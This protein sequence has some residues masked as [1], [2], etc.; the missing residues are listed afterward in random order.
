MKMKNLFK[1]AV[2]AG[3]I[4]A[5]ITVTA[6]NFNASA[7]VYWK[8][9]YPNAEIDDIDTLCTQTNHY[10]VYGS[11]RFLKA[12]KKGDIF[13]DADGSS[14][15]AGH[16]AIVEGVFYN[17]KYNKAYIRL[18]EAPGNGQLVKRNV[19]DLPRFCNNR[20][21]KILR[22]K[23]VTE[24]QITSA[25]EFCQ[26][27]IGIQYPTEEL[28]NNCSAA[29]LTFSILAGNIPAIFSN[30]RDIWLNRPAKNY[31]PVDVPYAEKSWYCSELIYAAYYTATNGAIDLNPGDNFCWP[32]EIRDSEYV[33]NV[34]LSACYSYYH[35]YDDPELV[36]CTHAMH[37][38]VF[39]GYDIG[40]DYCDLVTESNGTQYCRDCHHSWNKPICA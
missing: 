15:I 25:I 40:Y 12:L 18:I 31:E 1:T 24:G 14:G 30:G 34:D 33:E 4:A 39:D 9:I 19:L 27:Q 36:N 28:S 23:N 29:A 5:S 7:E 38:V 3:T 20:K 8:S 11:E 13:F 37:K 17:K 6:S 32:K 35:D 10:F 26:R 2:F 22:P 21:N 16:I